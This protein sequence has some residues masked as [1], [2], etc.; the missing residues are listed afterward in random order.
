MF[1]GCTMKDRSNDP[2]YYEQTLDHGTTSPSRIGWNLIYLV[3]RSTV[4]GTNAGRYI[5]SLVGSG[6]KVWVMGLGWGLRGGCGRN[7]T[8]IKTVTILFARI[9]EGS[10]RACVPVLAWCEFRLNSIHTVKQERV[11]EI[12]GSTPIYL[13]SNVLKTSLNNTLIAGFHKG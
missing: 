7:F 2:S 9:R 11:P 10:W 8:Q 6:G 5:L 1:N 3:D 12:V 4:E 13:L